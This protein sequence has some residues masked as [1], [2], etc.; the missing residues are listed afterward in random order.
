MLELSDRARASLLHGNQ[1]RYVR[2]ESW[3]DNELLLDDDIPVVSGVEEVDRGSNV[4][5]RVRLTVPRQAGG[6]DYAPT[7]LLSPLA[8]NGQILRVQ[9]GINLGVDLIEWV[10]R[11]WYVIV[12]SETRGDT[13]EVECAGL[14]WKIQEA[15]LVAPIQP[16]GTFETTCRLLVEPALTVRTSDALADRVVPLSVTTSYDNDRLEALNATLRAWPAVADVTSDGYLLIDTADDSEDV[17]LELTSGQGGTVIERTAASTREGVY[18]AV[19]ASGTATD[20][21]AVRA[22][23]Y[24]L[25]G[26]KRSG[27]PFNEF[28]VALYYDSPLINTVAEATAAAKTRLQTAKRGTGITYDVEMVPHPALEVGDR[29]TLDGVHGIVEKLTLPLTPGGGSQR[30]FVR[31]VQ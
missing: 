15:G 5:E 4:P 9:I 21:G 17:S 7:E 19:V 18:N 8:A 3:Y 26:P 27:G 22:V 23:A 30:I 20:G 6:V 24:D 25:N 28:P 10:Q 2:V 11:G 29:V 12:G 13:V 14:L 31:E 16:C 1:R